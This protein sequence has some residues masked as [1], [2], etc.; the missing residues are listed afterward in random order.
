MPNYAPDAIRNHFYKW[1]FTTL[2]SQPHNICD[3]GPAK[4]GLAAYLSHIGHIVTT[5]EKNKLYIKDQEDW[6]K[7]FNCGLRILN[8]DI[9]ELNTEIFDTIISSYAIQHNPLDVALK[10]YL[11]CINL[12]RKPFG[13]MYVSHQY[14]HTIANVDDKRGPEGTLYTLGE[15]ELQ[16][17][18]TKIEDYLKTF[19][20]TP[21]LTTAFIR[22]EKAANNFWWNSEEPTFCQPNEATAVYIHIE[23]IQNEK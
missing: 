12:L 17:I 20:C 14:S 4:S 9:L 15:T 10:C 1:M 23:A 21:L 3:V 6:K 22:W 16:Q 13:N 5:V 7:E 11:H 19:N 18:L 2:P 8:Y